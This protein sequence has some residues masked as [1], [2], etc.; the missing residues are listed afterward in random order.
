MTD[1]VDLVNPTAARQPVGDPAP[2]LGSRAE[3]RV[4]LVDGMLHK[5]ALWGQGLLDAVEPA[6]AARRPTAVFDRVAL[7]PIRPEEPDVWAAVM[8]AR[9]EALVIAAGD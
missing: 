2:R 9:Y 7:D 4:A 3:L 5:K 8:A 6:V 1:P